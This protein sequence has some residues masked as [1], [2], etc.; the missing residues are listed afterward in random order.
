MS[1][2]PAAAGAAATLQVRWWGS[3]GRWISGFGGGLVGPCKG[4]QCEVRAACTGSIT[5][6]GAVLTSAHLSANGTGVDD[7][8]VWLCRGLGGACS[9]RPAGCSVGW[10][11][12]GWLVG[13]LV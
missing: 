7:E 3:V 2:Q 4:G 13:G 11:V 12:V 10:T 1:R 9:S 6:H 8:G 5:R